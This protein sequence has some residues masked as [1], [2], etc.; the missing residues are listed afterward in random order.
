M[1]ER[2][3]VAGSVCVHR[4]S[5][6]EPQ[7]LR[8]RC[9]TEAQRTQFGTHSRHDITHDAKLQCTRVI[10]RVRVVLIAGV[11]GVWVICVAMAVSRPPG[12]E[13]G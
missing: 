1:E 4:G 8:C 13:L 6:C 10:G 2:W 7:Q 3:I 11:L 9:L 5:A 12:G